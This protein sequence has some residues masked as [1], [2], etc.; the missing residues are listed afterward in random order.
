MLAAK[1]KES[2]LRGNNLLVLAIPRGGVIVGKELA[3]A[4]NCPLDVVVTKKIGTPENPELAI[5]AVSAFG[6]PSLNEE[7]AKKTGAGEAYIK[8]QISK[9]KIE[10]QEREKIFRSGKPPLNLKDKIVILT[11]DGV[12][13]GATMVVAVE[14]VR[15]QSP[16]RIIVA[17]PVIAKDTLARIEAVAD[18]VVYLEAPEMFFAVGQFYQD[19]PQITD[20]EVL[21]LLQ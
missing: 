4:L 20:A 9:I 18:E 3:T 17:V 19:F 16:K 12:A 7:L 5:G 13:T 10:I 15:Q 14:I 11:D 2:E 6:E 21:K 8:D 1:I